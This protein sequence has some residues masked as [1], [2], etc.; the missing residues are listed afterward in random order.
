MSELTVDQALQKAIAAHKTGQV[1]EADRLYTAI[2][3]A[4][5]LHPDANHNM[6]VLT[7]SVGKVEQ[8]LPFFKT[9]LEANPA[10]AQYWL[11]YIDTLIK[12]DKLADAKAVLDQAKSNG[13]KGDGF[14]QLE[15]RLKD[16]TK[17]HLSDTAIVKPLDTNQRSILDK[18]IKLRERGEF[19]QAIDFL[20]DEVNRAPN[21]ADMFALL[22]H[23]HLLGNQVAEA[24]LY[25]DKAKRIAPD[26]ASVRWNTVRLTLKEQK[27]LEALNIAKDTSQRFPD[28]IEGMGVF[29]AC[30]RANGEISKSLDVLNRSIELNPNYA[31]ALITRGAIR[32]S[33]KN[34]PDALADLELAH[35]L[36]LIS[37][38]SG[39]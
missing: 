3:K 22:S 13:A 32:L 9:A 17:E 2:L 10:T 36:S 19:K 37:N 38:K 8:A 18:A 21:N 24:K 16:A 14:D 26:N 6:G 7:V 29:G 15:Q 35:R 12:L 28:D 30:L 31:G 20:K 33:Q 39:I 25:L 5:P 1:Q 4:Q 23:C 34:K 11:S 27:P